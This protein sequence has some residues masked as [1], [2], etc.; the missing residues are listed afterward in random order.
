MNIL[1]R[2]HLGERISSVCE[3]IKSYAIRFAQK[4]AKEIRFDFTPDDVISFI[5]SGDREESAAHLFEFAAR[6]PDQS[7]ENNK[8]LPLIGRHKK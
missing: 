3:I 7:T 5:N 2:I 4:Y 8:Q 6:Q 1:Q